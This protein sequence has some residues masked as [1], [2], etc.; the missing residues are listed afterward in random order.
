MT[1]SRIRA[2]NTQIYRISLEHPVMLGNKKV[3]GKNTMM[4]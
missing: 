3:G 2:G 4:G 1:D